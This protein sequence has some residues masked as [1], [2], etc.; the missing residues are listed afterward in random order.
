MKFPRLTTV[1]AAFFVTTCGYPGSQR[2]VRSDLRTMIQIEEST[3]LSHE[4]I[5]SGHGLSLVTSDRGA[6]FKTWA[7][8]RKLMLVTLPEANDLARALATAETTLAYSPASQEHAGFALVEIIDR[9]QETKLAHA[10]HAGAQGCGMLQR[11]R[12]LDN[13]TSSGN[14]VAPVFIESVKRQAVAD[15]ANLNPATVKSS[16]QSTIQS[17]ENLGTRFHTTTSGLSAPATIKSLF[18]AAAG[19]NISGLTVKLVPHAD[20]NQNSVI[21]TIPGRDDPSA[22]GPT[23]IIGA[24]LDSINSAGEQNPAPGADDDASGIATLIE[25][26]RQ[27]ASR[28]ARFQRTIELH[29]YAAEEVG[30]I[31]SSEI[32]ESYQRAQRQVVAMMQYDMD[33]WASD[34]TSETIYLVTNSTKAVLRRS[35][36]TLLNSYLG[37][38]VVEGTLRAGQSDHVSWTAAGF[39]TVFPFENPINYNQALHS[40]RDTSGTINN[41]NLSA[42]F[43]QSGLVFLSHLAGL[44]S[45]E[46]GYEADLQTLRSSLGRDLFIAINAGSKPDQFNL[47]VSGASGVKT[48]EIC[49]AH[50]AG[51]MTCLKESLGSNAG[52]VKGTRELFSIATDIAIRSGIHLSIFGYNAA[53]QLVAQRSVRIEKK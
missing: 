19:G 3:T 11:L 21:V 49:E 1:I 9:E 28:G 13:S 12:L 22:S 10:A 18:E 46:S 8:D 48:V 23:V 38:N 2:F 26:T 47:F 25:I 31:G 52:T 6:N 35:L 20:S 27:I 4:L 43:V 32:A 15:L 45:A 40:S 50:Q 37:G 17:L 14:F 34:P 16:L 53:D 44:T 30:L 51:A 5:W 42:R 29:A 33:A 7:Q 39:N 36:R 41:L 24:H